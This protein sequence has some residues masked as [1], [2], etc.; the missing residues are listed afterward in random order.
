MPKYILPLAFLLTCFTVAAQDVDYKKGLIQVDG[1]DYAKIEVQ[2]KNFGLTKDFEVFSMGG[3]KL[4]I[5]ALASEFQQD[6]SDNSVM[7][8]RVTFLTANQVGIFK[9]PALSQE[10][11]FAKL[12]GSSGIIQGDTLNEQK[13]KEFIA[14]KGAS[15]VM[16]VDYTTVSRNRGWPVRIQEDKNIEQDGKI[17]GSFVPKGTL[18]G[19]SYYQ[20]LLPSGVV[21]AEVSFTGGN[22]AQNMEVFTKKDNY[23]RV[24]PIPQKETIKLASTGIDQN[25]F[26]LVRIAKWLVESQYL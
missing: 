2:K 19:Q 18:N 13:V 10:K 17:I 11:G 5:A 3:K 8:Y 14:A 7:Y 15:P 21:I 1:K 9:I 4:I 26:T 22:N 6:K 12:I 24:V 25:Y 20:F 16:A 23:K